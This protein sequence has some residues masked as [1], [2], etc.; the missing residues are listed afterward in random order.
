MILDGQP[1]VG[2]AAI[3]NSH[4]DDSRPAARALAAAVSL[5]SSLRD[6]VS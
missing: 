5:R 2:G 1:D 4:R 3:S 6:S